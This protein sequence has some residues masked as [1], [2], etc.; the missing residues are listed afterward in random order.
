MPVAARFAL[1]RTGRNNRDPKPQPRG[2]R[3]RSIGRVAPDGQAAFNVALR[4]L[5][6]EIGRSDRPGSGSAPGSS[7]DSEPGD[8]WREDVAKGAFVEGQRRFDLIETMAFDPFA[9]IAELDR[10][11]NRMKRSADAL[12]FAFDR[13]MARNELQ[14]ATF[15]AGPSLVRLLL[16]RSGA[17][18]IELRE[19]PQRADRTGRSGGRAAAGRRRRFPAGPQDQRPRLPRRKRA[20]PPARSRW[21]IATKPAS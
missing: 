18:A 4:T 3:C 21:C 13:H 6:L 5:T 12:G 8:E 15:R 17:M 9:G 2:I 11:L 14:A 20:P 7:A 10:H 1:L 19:L 16:S